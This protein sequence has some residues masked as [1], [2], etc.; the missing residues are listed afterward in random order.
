M[1]FIHA[2]D[3]V[4]HDT[5]GIMFPQMQ[6]SNGGLL[7]YSQSEARKPCRRFVS[8]AK[9]RVLLKVCRKAAEQ[10]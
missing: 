2:G 1:S 6:E 4:E 9:L 7:E 3:M 10:V 5:V 8:A